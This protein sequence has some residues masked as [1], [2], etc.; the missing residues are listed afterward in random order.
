MLFADDVGDGA[1]NSIEI[2]MHFYYRFTTTYS[3]VTGHAPVKLKF[4]LNKKK[5]LLFKVFKI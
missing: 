1:Q 3:T 5:K 4:L 2:E